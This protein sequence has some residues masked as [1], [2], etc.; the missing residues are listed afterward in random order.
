M[1]RRAPQPHVA[2]QITRLAIISGMAGSGSNLLPL[3]YPRPRPLSFRI[4]I[5]PFPNQAD[6]SL[7]QDGM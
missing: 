3:G 4:P 6:F 5:D 7:S 2:R 1:L